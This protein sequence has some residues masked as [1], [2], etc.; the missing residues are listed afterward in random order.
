MRG[1]SLAHRLRITRSNVQAA[2]FDRAVHAFARMRWA[3]PDA[4]PARFDV[5]LER[6]IPYRDSR[7]PSHTLDVYMPMRAAKPLPTILYVHGGGFSMLSKETHRGMALGYARRGYLVFLINYRLGPRHTFP[8][9]L[10]DACE[11]MQW[12]YAHCARYGG[13]PTRFAIAGESAG[14]NLV[15]AL[16][17]ASC[18]RRPEPFA[19]RLFDAA[20][21]V[22]ATVATYGF[23]DLEGHTRHLEH[24]RLSS[25]VKDLVIHATASYVGTDLRAGC[26]A[27]PL[28]SP[29]LLLEQATKVDRPLPP[30]FADVGTRDPLIRDS[31]RL[32][33][34]VERLG[35][36]CELHIAP[37]E[38]HGY[39]ALPWRPAAKEKWRKVNAFLAPHMAR[40]DETNA[41]DDQRTA[42]AE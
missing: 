32:K 21:P 37:G 8:A 23:L 31:K 12:A 36:T 15:T 40:A 11:A 4:H 42:A 7:D 20:I 29:L 6:D 33:E 39:D 22:R 17:V 1:V 5:V 25:M 30:F 19:A 38:M 3:F 16:T 2:A 10:E 26:A 14:G 24:P 9:P 18:I 41:P 35:S 13:D 28:A 34:A 27:A